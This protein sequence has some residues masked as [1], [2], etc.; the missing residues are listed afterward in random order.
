MQSSLST[1]TKIR[2]PVGDLG[3]A[4]TLEITGVF[5]DRTALTLHKRYLKG[6]RLPIRM[7]E[8]SKIHMA[9]IALLDL[10]PV[11]QKEFLYALSR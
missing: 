8:P 3:L 6:L 5:D 7:L 2:Y 11:T 10:R 9:I 1:K 4:L